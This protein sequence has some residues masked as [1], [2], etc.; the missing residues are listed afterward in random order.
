MTC[1][2]T[3]S[4]VC[5][6]LAAGRSSRMGRPKATLT[7]AGTTLLERALAAAAAYP[8]VVVI[9]ELPED[10]MALLERVRRERDLIVVTNDAPQRGMSRSLALGDAAIGSRGA[11]LA[12]LLL[13][14]P[15]VDATLV[16]RV[17]AARGD[18]DIAF[19]THG[20]TPGHPVV[21]GPRA[22]EAI[23][24][25]PDG[26]TLRTLR[27]DVRW[28]RI[29]VACDGDAPFRDIDTPNDYADVSVES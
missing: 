8:T 12:V 13:D 29:T 24:S 25:L 15:F 2:A 11:A 4:T 20:A 14:T 22:R 18:A 5:A 10:A 6:I 16:A 1:A 21:F 26:D 7:V 27:D 9:A 28:R 3:P 17:V 23:A 19:P